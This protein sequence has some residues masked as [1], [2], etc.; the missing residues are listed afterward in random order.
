MI[1]LLR[2]VKIEGMKVFDRVRTWVFLGL[3]IVL[4][5]LFAMARKWMENTTG[6]AENTGDF[7][8]NSSSLLFAVQLLT[9]VIAG[10]IVSSEFAWG[11][12]KLLLIRPVNRTKILYSKYIVVL[13][14]ALLCMAVLLL[15]S[16]LFGAVFF[17]LFSLDGL[18]FLRETGIIYGFRFV[19]IAIV[20]SMA[21]M[22]S[23]LS[24]SSSLGV[25][26]SIF[27]VFA[28]MLTAEGM[29]MFGISLGKFLLFAN[30]DLTQYREEATPAF[31]GM[32][33]GFSIVVLSVYFLLFHLISW[34]SFTKRDIS[35]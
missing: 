3:L 10:E 6:L 33:P 19:E 22:L 30:L 26:L 34:I 24:R 35:I 18:S 12:V 32:T 7:V 21:F 2:L 4:P 15:S 20:A 8:L 5:F 28:G 17:R 16:I 1:D 25:G 14:F 27:L 23:T 13:L 9:I 29:E 31:P 11:T